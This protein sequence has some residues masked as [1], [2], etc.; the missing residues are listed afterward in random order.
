MGIFLLP[1]NPQLLCCQCMK[2]RRAT[3]IDGERTTCVRRSCT[4]SE[5]EAETFR[6]SLDLDL[7]YQSYIPHHYSWFFPGPIFQSLCMNSKLGSISSVDTY[8]SNRTTKFSTVQQS[9]ETPRASFL[10][11]LSQICC[12]WSTWRVSALPS[13]THWLSSRLVIPCI[14]SPFV[15]SSLRHD[16]LHGC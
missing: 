13:K 10:G 3:K 15:F 11:H 8:H 7:L 5:S 6:V 14:A 9:Q 4:C 2:E 16:V 12:I 1:H